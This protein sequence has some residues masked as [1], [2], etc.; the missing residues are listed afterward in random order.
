MRG[1]RAASTRWRGRAWSIGRSISAGP[2]RCSSS[3]RVSASIYG[4]SAEE[5][6]RAANS[7]HPRERPPQ[8]P[9]GVLSPLHP[10]DPLPIPPP[11]GGGKSLQPSPPNSPTLLTL[12]RVGKTFANSVVALDQLDLAVRE[13]EFVALLGPSGCGKSTAVRLL[14]SV[15]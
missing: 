12:R 4:R 1:C 9:G 15:S 7:A 10:R 14:G 6:D 5:A 8:R 3:P 13:G 11:S 2:I